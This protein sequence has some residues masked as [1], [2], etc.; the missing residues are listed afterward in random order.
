MRLALKRREKLGGLS[1]EGFAE[2]LSAVSKNYESFVDDNEEEAFHKVERGLKRLN[3][4]EILDGSLDTAHYE[5]ARVRK[6]ATLENDMRQ[7]VALDPLCA[8]ARNLLIMSELR[9]PDLL[10]KAFL[11]LEKE[12]EEKTGPIQKGETGDAWDDVFQH[13]RLRLANSIARYMLESGRYRLTVKRCYDLMELN[14]SD[15]LGARYTCALALARLEDEE[16]FNW[17]DAREGRHGNA[18]FHLSRV[19]LMYKLGRMAAARRAL[20]GYDQLCTGGAY[21]LLQPVFMDV[22]LPDRPAWQPQSFDESVLAVHEA[23][24]IIAD[25]PDFAAWTCDQPGFLA[26][27]Q[28]YARR[29]GF[30]WRPWE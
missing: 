12:L 18:W 10:L 9:S 11:D 1:D 29:N 19:I 4:D 24:P 15:A 13:P 20:R 5:V 26:S 14:P 17:I 30:E 22:Y 7:A 8:D 28:E 27:A 6:M 3:L 23:D 25:I 2:L 21:A 16:G